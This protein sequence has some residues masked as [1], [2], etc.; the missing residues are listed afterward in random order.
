MKKILT[1]V[2]LCVA[3]S[4]TACQDDLDCKDLNS[5]DVNV[6]DVSLNK[7][8]LSLAEATKETLVA[9]V[10]PDKATEKTVTWSSDKADIATVSATGEVTAIKAGTATITVKTKDGGKT[11]TCAVTVTPTGIPVTG[12]T[13]NK[14]ELSLKVEETTTLVATVAPEDA[15]N[16]NVKWNSDKPEIVTISDQSVVTAV[17]SG[18]AIITATTEDG[19]KTATCKVTVTIAPPLG[20]QVGDYFYKDGSYST[21]YVGTEANPC[22][23]VVFWIDPDNAKKGKIVSLDECSANWNDWKNWKSK[24]VLPDGMTWRA[25]D[26]DET[27]YL[28]CFYAGLPPQT[29]KNTTRPVG[30]ETSGA[31]EKAKAIFEYDPGSGKIGDGF[32]SMGDYWTTVKFGEMMGH[33]MYNVISFYNGAIQGATDSNKEIGR[34]VCDFTLND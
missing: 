11:A 5:P 26:M 15:T 32:S 23:G 21:A 25:M 13:L 7:T 4:F 12:I 20:I 3:L 10:S 18:E 1:F 2:L 34:C 14:T 28:Y 33:I 16:K 22:L 17:A 9:T 29:W 6:T 27:Q 24:N 30:D 19:N 8:T 31:R